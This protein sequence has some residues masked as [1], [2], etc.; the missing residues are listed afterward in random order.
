MIRRLILVWRQVQEADGSYVVSTLGLC[1]GVLR[2][3]IGFE[4]SFTQTDNFKRLMGRLKL[5][6]HNYSS[7][8]KPSVPAIIINESEISACRTQMMSSVQH[9]VSQARL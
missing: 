6:F 3:N 9:L 1:G 8:R 5:F 4:G 7:P 2:Q